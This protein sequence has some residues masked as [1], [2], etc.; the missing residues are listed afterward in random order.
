[1]RSTIFCEVY[2]F[3]PTTAAS[4]DGDKIVLSGIIMVMGIKQPEFKGISI[5][6]NDLKQ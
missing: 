2:T 5:P 4:F 6:I 1:M 3:P